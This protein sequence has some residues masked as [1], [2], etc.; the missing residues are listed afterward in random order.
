MSKLLGELLFELAR[1]LITDR[2]K[3]LL[4]QFIERGGA[5]LDPMIHGRW[6]RLVVGLLLGLAAYAIFPV[7][8]ILLKN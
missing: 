8:V 2:V 6:T 1:S 4:W 3:G 7:M 5:W